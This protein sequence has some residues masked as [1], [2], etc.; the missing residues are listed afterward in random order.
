MLRIYDKVLELKNSSN[1]QEIFAEIWGVK[2]FAQQPVT[3]VEFQLRRDVLKEFENKVETV[4]NLLFAL[5][6][7]WTY[8]TQSWCRFSDQKIDRNHNQSRAKNS[9]FWNEVS[10]LEWTGIHTIERKKRCQNK[11]IDQIKANMRGMAMTASAFFDPHPEDL[12]HII[13][14]SQDILRD[15]LTK[16][17]KDDLVKFTERMKRKRN[18]IYSN[19]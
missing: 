5:K 13:G 2:C 10:N 16:L 19:I 14:I 11:S 1:K 9:E 6:A 17:Y 7:L 3:R 15:E 4:K 18:E 8:C 12:D